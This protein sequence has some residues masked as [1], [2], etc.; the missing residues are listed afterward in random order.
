MKSYYN[1]YSSYVYLCSTRVSR[2]TIMRIDKSTNNTLTLRVPTGT[3]KSERFRLVTDNIDI[4]IT[5][6]QTIVEQ[7]E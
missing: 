4:R 7:T 5:D 6:A 3:I 1:L 2:Q